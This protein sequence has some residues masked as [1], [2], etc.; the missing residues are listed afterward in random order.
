MESVRGDASGGDVV[1]RR[2]G[3][4][5][6]GGAPA[7]SASGLSPFPSIGNFLTLSILI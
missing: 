1:R 3:G 2:G 5:D 4:S 7:I 6:E